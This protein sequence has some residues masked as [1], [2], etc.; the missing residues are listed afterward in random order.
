MLETATYWNP[1]L[2]SAAAD[3]D[4]KQTKSKNLHTI[5]LGGDVTICMYPLPPMSLFV[6]NFGYPLP[7]PTLV[8]SFLNDPLAIY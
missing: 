4:Q 5:F 6:T 3:I 1:K 2:S 7:P 8:A